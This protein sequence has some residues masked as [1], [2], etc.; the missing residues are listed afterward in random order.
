M[1]GPFVESLLNRD[2][3]DILSALSAEGVEFLIVGAY[4]V[5]A[6]GIPRA[7]GD[8][9]IWVRPTRENASRVMR[10]LKQFGAALLDLTEADLATEHTV[11]QM[12]VAPSRID[13]ITGISGVS[14]DQAWP[15]RITVAIEGLTVPVI[16]R[17]DLLRNKAAS[18]RPKDLAD[19]VALGDRRAAKKVAKKGAA[20]AARK[21]SAR[22]SGRSRPR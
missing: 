19:L 4:A 17:D 10:A 3:N 2:Y 5:G 11:F 20:K 9:D 18:G 7:T 16:G 12:G 6:H 13:V 14:F 22:K 21:T 1:R 15:A 8:I